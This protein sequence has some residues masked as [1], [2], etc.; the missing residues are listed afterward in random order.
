MRL[1]RQV[2]AKPVDRST[3]VEW[4]NVIICECTNRPLKWFD[5]G[6][7]VGRFVRGGNEDRY[8]SVKPVGCQIDYFITLKCRHHILN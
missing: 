6:V 2:L 8:I 4:E 3:N 1:K 7:D 5:D